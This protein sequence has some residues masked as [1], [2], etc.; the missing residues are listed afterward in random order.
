MAAAKSSAAFATFPCLIN[1]LPRKVLERP[2]R[3]LRFRPT[4][5]TG[6][7]F[8]SDA[9]SPC[10]PLPHRCPPPAASLPNPPA[11]PSLVPAP[12]C[13]LGQHKQPAWPSPPAHRTPVPSQNPAWDGCASQPHCSPGRAGPKAAWDC[14]ETAAEASCGSSPLVT[15][16]YRASAF[17]GSSLITAV[18]SLMAVFQVDLS[19]KYIPCFMSA[20]VL[21]GLW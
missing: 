19:K 6:F 2:P 16:A 14:A 21:L 15:R 18:K 12:P 8:H 9:L 5:E 10:S 17:A 4:T 3:E 7:R 20:S 1:A 13:S 11:P